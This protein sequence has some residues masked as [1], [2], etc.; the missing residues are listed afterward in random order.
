[1][2]TE[3]ELELVSEVNR[4]PLEPRGCRKLCVI[5]PS[6]SVT[7]AS[8][9]QGRLS[10]ELGEV[11]A[12]GVDRRRQLVALVPGRFALEKLRDSSH[13]HEVF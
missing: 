13:K 1:M 11:G 2:Q 4:L 7:S 3:E 9:R 8:A 5:S 10:D 12:G 6:M